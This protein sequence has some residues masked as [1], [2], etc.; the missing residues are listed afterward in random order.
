MDNVREKAQHTPAAEQVAAKMGTTE[1]FILRD[2][3]TA[4]PMVT[5]PR[6][7]GPGVCAVLCWLCVPSSE[8]QRDA[9]TV[10]KAGGAEACPG[11]LDYREARLQS[12]P[13][14]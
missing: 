6:I 13:A 9:L 3:L 1:W 2:P 7:L 14:L 5:I 11:A 12:I 10:R 8:E 4:C